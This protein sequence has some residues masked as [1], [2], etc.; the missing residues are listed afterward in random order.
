MDI[1]SDAFVGTIH[2]WQLQLSR[3]GRGR[4][5]NLVTKLWS[6]TDALQ[7]M[8][9]SLWWGA[10]HISRPFILILGGWPPK[11][12]APSPGIID[13]YTGWCHAVDDADKRVL[14]CQLLQPGWAIGLTDACVCVLRSI[15]TTRC[16]GSRINA[17]ANCVVCTPALQSRVLTSKKRPSCLLLLYHLPPPSFQEGQGC[18]RPY[19]SR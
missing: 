18:Q 19:A 7:R 9:R 6:H 4:S 2:N 3:V 17:F 13:D 12:Y 8:L 15:R 5:K 10:S 16:R 1:L 11:P 14:S